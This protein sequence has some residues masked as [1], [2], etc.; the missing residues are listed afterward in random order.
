MVTL[1]SLTAIYRAALYRY[2]AVGAVS[3][4]FDQALISGAFKR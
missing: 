2:A 4:Q 1:N 3:E